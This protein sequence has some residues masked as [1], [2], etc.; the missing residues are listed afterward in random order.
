MKSQIKT[1]SI[2][3]YI[4]VLLNILVGFIMSPITVTAL[5]S[6][7][8][9]L[10]Q[11]IWSFVGYLA[12][13]DF[14]F[15]NA[16]IRY[17]AKYRAAGDK[18]GEQNFLA[19]V[20]IIYAIISLCIL[21][22][23]GVLYFNLEN[24]FERSLSLSDLV[25]AKQLFL[26]MLSNMSVSMM[27]NVFQATING[28]E[29][30][31]FQRGL[32]ILRIVVRTVLAIILLFSGYKSIALAV[33]D[34]AM[35]FVF[36]LIQVYY[37]FFVMKIKIRLYEFNWKFFGEIFFYSFFIFL[38]IIS[39]Q[40]NWKVNQF[41]IGIKM[42][43]SEVGIYSIAIQFPIYF[44]SFAG[45]LSGIFLPRATKMAFNNADG[46]QFTDLM[47]KIARIQWTVLGI[48]FLG[49]AFF[50][51]EFIVLWV[52]KDFEVGYVVA[53]LIMAALFIPHLQ[54]VGPSI[55][56][57][58]KKDYFRSITY[59]FIAVANV[60]VTYFMVDVLGLVG[61]ALGTALSMVVGNVIIMNIYY[62][63]SLKLEIFRFFTQTAK[64]LILSSIIVI[65]AGFIISFNFPAHSWPALIIKIIVFSVIYALAFYFIG[66]NKGEKQMLKQII[67]TYLGRKDANEGIS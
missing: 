56:Q 57:A 50:G 27:L 63:R 40:I 15:T 29:N 53:L 11:L 41:I 19:I 1:G 59:F 46:A 8:F 23:G 51:R 18:K 24:I 31:A 35:A 26:I 37:C 39:E 65:M 16:I 42:D 49:F 20:L 3:S 58:K 48:L 32:V 22:I 7:Q 14:G 36:F 5:G 52:G 45:A 61:A 33:L 67:S 30:F 43:V 55:L 9:G 64:G 38:A 6:H 47:I 4:G 25:L 62:K 66:L 21:V 13:L 60:F 12:V 54:S 44:M 28:Y 17:V 2:F 34:T 10:Y